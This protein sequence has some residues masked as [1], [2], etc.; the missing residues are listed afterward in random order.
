VNWTVHEGVQLH[1]GINNVADKDPPL[2]SGNGLAPASPPF[3]NGNTYPQ[4][5]DALGRYVFVGATIKY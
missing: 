4:V 3:G 5:Y 2:L 1:A